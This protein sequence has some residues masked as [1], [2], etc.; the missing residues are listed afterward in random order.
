M[1]KARCNH[2][3][4]SKNHVTVYERVTDKVMELLV[5]GVVPWQKP[6]ETHVCPPRNGVSGRPYRGLSVFLLSH[7]GYDSP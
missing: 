5:Q 4:G 3:G 6:W 7:A 2:S 1:Q